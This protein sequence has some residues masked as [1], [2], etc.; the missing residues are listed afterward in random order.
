MIDLAIDVLQII[1]GSFLLAVSITY[2]CCVWTR[3]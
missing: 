1:V 3:E 2:I